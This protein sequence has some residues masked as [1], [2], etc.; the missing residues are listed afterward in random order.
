VW[1]CFYLGQRSGVSTKLGPQ[2]S[3]TPWLRVNLIALAL[4]IYTII[5]II[6]LLASY[7]YD[8]RLDV[9][10]L[11]LLNPGEAYFDKFLLK[12]IWEGQTN[13]LMQ[14]YTL[15]NAF[16]LL[17]VPVT[18]WYWHALRW[19]T[20]LLAIG[21]IVS[22]V[23]PGVMTGTMVDVGLVAVEISVSVIT[24]IATGR[25][26]KRASRKLLWIALL[27]GLIFVFFAINALLGRADRMSWR[28]WEG[29]E[30]W[31]Y[32][33]NNLLTPILGARLAFGVYSLISYVTHGYEGLGQC[34]QLPFVWTYGIGHSRA[35]MEYAAQYLGWDWI[36]DRHYLWRNYLVTGRHPLM[37]WST[38][39][40]WIA[41]DTTFVGVLPVIFLIGKFFGKI[42]K[43]L[44]EKGNPITLALFIR[45]VVLVLFL[46]AN[47]QIFQGR[48]MWWGTMGLLTLYFLSKR[49]KR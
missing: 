16:V 15:T 12:D 32:N 24:L 44:L 49:S 35:L 1:L 36:W 43:E 22:K 38:A 19:P 3:S 6:K 41:S 27:S 47:F 33:P 5:L 34:M 28:P 21:A 42:W 31:Y 23:V 46:P 37:Y 4:S 13:F 39:L 9:L 7:G 10:E 20:R 26:S 2:H 25:I 11:S 29:G 14:L 30:L 48:V 17:V 18:F 40:V 45:L 8:L